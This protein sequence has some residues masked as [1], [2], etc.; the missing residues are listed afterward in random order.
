[1]G[2]LVSKGAVKCKLSPTTEYLPLGK[3]MYPLKTL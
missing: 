2:F 3:L 1:M